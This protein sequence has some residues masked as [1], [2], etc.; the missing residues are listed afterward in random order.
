SA[1]S[2]AAT[3]ATPEKRVV[4]N[5]RL[6]EAKRNP[7]RGKY[8]RIVLPDVDL[9]DGSSFEKEKRPL[10]GMLS[11]IELGETDG[12]PQSKVSPESGPAGANQQQPKPDDPKTGGASSPQ[13]VA[14]TPAAGGAAEATPPNGAQGGGGAGQQIPE[15]QMAAGGGANGQPPPG[16]QATP[17]GAGPAAAAE[18]MQAANLN[19]PEGAAGAVGAA[20]AKPQQMQIGDATLQIQTAAQNNSDVVGTQ[21]STAQQ[22]DRKTPAGGSPSPS[23]GNV[24]VEKG[25]VV[26]KGL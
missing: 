11:E 20:T 6:P 26:P 21:A 16:G 8:G 13:N 3:P 1:A 9:L 19:V 24:G 17:G 2:P 18:G 22:Y 15:G 5:G 7:D 12:G 10:R 4:P 14:Q 25:R 23:S